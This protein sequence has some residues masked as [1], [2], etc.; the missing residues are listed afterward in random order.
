MTSEV[1]QANLPLLI[2]GDGEAE[3]G[4]R[5]FLTLHLPLIIPGSYNS[6]RDLESICKRY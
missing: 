5:P 2:R 3:K 1:G 4:R 6:M